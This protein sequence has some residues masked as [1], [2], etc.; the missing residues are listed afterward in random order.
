MIF[1]SK[2]FYAELVE[3]KNLKEVLEVYNSNGNFLI[4]H[5]DRHTV[6][7]EWIIQEIECMRDIGFHSC[8]IVETTRGK[9]V[10]IMDFKVDKETYLSLLMIHKDFQGKGFGKLIYQGFEQYV[11]SLKS[12]CIRIDVVTNYD[13]SALNFWIN[14]GFI[15]FKDVELNWTGKILPAVTMNRFI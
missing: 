9:T 11:K 1:Q 14:N 12:K 15:K 3:N 13:N 2:G 8:K 7:T 10:G 6:T 5:M 4:D